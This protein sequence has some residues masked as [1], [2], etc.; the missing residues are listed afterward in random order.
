M[1]VLSITFH[2]PIDWLEKWEIFVKDSLSKMAENLLEVEHY[3]LSEVF[4]EMI[5][6]GKNYNLLLFFES[7]QKRTEFLAHEFLN[8][9]ERIEMAFG[10]EIMIFQTLLN[11]IQSRME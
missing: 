3:V 7:V 1:S 8:I 11:P 10:H 2:C 4:S 5:N 6:E 9:I